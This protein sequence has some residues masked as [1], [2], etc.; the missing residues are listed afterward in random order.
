M[1]HLIFVALDCV[2]LALYY[3]V[4]MVLTADF[5]KHRRQGIAVLL[6]F[7][8]AETVY[9][10]YLT[11]ALPLEEYADMSAPENILLSFVDIVFPLCFFAYYMKGNP[12][13][14]FFI[15]TV[16]DMAALLT[17]GVFSLVNDVLFPDSLPL[18]YADSWSDLPTLLFF[19]LSYLLP[20]LLFCRFRLPV[21]TFIYGLPRWLI[22]GVLLLNYLLDTA[23]FLLFGDESFATKTD[24]LTLLVI[25]L[26][27][28]LGTVIPLLFAAL[29]RKH[30][31]EAGSWKLIELEMQLE[32]DYY[33]TMHDLSLQLRKLRHDMVNHM[34]I[35]QA[36]QEID[37][38]ER[39]KYRDQLLSYCEETER[40]MKYAFPDQKNFLPTLTARENY[41]VFSFVR[42]IAQGCSI[43]PEDISVVR[44]GDHLT[45]T[46][47]AESK[48]LD[49]KS[50][51][52]DTHY[53]L[54]CRIL[55]EKGGAAV[56]EKGEK[57]WTLS[58]NT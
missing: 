19:F 35:L 29:L 46:F 45:A 21:R 27:V 53:D 12:L 17:A 31:D 44:A 15:T 52:C 54:L 50:L 1:G 23:L 42:H 2:F 20:I 33:R 51:R 16:V 9:D 3:T 39:L 49:R 26:I 18:V 32:Y 4:L 56:W 25:I 10:W 6:V 57:S 13:V 37:E 11:Y 24:N 7:F 22:Y 40:T 5:K 8:L 28:T 41:A 38:S 34:T 58:I 36:L 43:A 30:R 48:H 55:S 47:H 14:N